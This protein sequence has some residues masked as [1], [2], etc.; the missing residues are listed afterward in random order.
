MIGWGAKSVCMIDLVTVSGTF[1]GTKRNLRRWQMH[2][3]A[4][5]SYS[6]GMLIPTEW[7]QGKIVINR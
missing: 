3:F 7:S 5:S 6:A 2:E 4:M 1:L